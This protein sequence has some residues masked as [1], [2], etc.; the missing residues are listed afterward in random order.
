MGR[1]TSE[2]PQVLELC[3]RMEGCSDSWS[4][5]W[6]TLGWNMPGGHYGGRNTPRMGLLATATRAV[7]RSFRRGPMAALGLL[8]RQR[9]KATVLCGVG[10]RLQLQLLLVRQG[11]KEFQEMQTMLEPWKGSTEALGRLWRQSTGSPGPMWAA[12]IERRYVL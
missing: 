2:G 4:R 6:S 11:M 8:G 1:P 10:L 12:P 5:S 9:P 3:R 7:W